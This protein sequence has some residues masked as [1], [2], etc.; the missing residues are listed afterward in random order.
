MAGGNWVKEIERAV[1]ASAIAILLLSSAFVAS[2]FIDSQE[3]PR[4][5]EGAASDGVVILPLVV[6]HCLVDEIRCIKDLQLFNDPDAPLRRLTSSE[7]DE[8]LV[9]FARTVRSIVTE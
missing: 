8:I 9:D 4:I 7:V 2:D 6:G 1:D 5:A 3:L